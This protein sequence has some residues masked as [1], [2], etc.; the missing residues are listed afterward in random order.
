MANTPH[1]RVKKSSIGKKGGRGSNLFYDLMRKRNRLSPLGKR[2]A[3]ETITQNIK[4]SILYRKKSDFKHW[5]REFSR[6]AY[7]SQLPFTC[8][9]C[10]S[11]KHIEIHHTVY[12]F[13]VE[14]WHCQQLCRSCHMKEESSKIEW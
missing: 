10:G 2:K 7:K 5:I 13:P 3:L 1:T 6:L 12:K 8:E 11:D 9:K 4:R 14:L